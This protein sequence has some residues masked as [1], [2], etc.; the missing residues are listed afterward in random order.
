[1]NAKTVLVV[2]DEFSIRR[3]LSRA[4]EGPGVQVITAD[5]VSTAETLL[6]YSQVDLILCD[7]QMPGENGLSFLRRLK[8]QYPEMVRALITGNASFPLTVEAVND[9]AVHYFVLKPFEVSELQELVSDLLG[10]SDRIEQSPPRAFTQQQRKELR[11]LAAKHPGIGEVRRDTAGAIVLD[12]ENCADARL[13]T[14]EEWR[15]RDAPDTGV[16]E[17]GNDFLRMLWS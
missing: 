9:A 1:M 5:T 4:L 14:G 3:L 11:S 10:W 2:D 6:L 12:D 17:F 15:Q 7:Y 16:I 13:T 8:E